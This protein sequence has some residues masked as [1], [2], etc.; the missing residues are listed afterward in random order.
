VNV[1]LYPVPRIVRAYLVEQGVGFEWGG[2]GDWPIATIAVPKSPK[3]VITVFDEAGVKRGRS[4]G[5]GVLEDP[6]VTIDIRSEEQEPGH[7]RATLIM[8]AMDA[9]RNW[10]WNGSSEEGGQTIKFATARR[11]RGVFPLGV[12]ENGC[13][14]HNLEYALVVQSIE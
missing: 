4:L 10:T 13:C 14:R 3:N 7:Y 8:Q 11:A 5:S 2:S 6:S 9:L 1:I 12:D